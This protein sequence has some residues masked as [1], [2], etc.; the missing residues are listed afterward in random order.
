MA[1]LLFGMSKCPL[2]GQVIEQGQ[3]TW[4]FP[5]FVLNELDPCFFFSDGAFHE[6]CVLKHKLGAYVHQ[7]VEEWASRVGPGKRKCAVCKAEVTDPDDYLQIEHLS[8]REG[9]PL[10]IFNYTHLHKS[11]LPIWESRQ[12]F[13]ELATAVLTLGSWKGCYL[14]QLIKEMK[15][16]Q[17]K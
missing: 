16:V 4:S 3:S 11:C 10:R 7:R 17:D 8:D 15:A 1:L 13:I 2:C 5:A 14:A 6:Q 12:H 9:D